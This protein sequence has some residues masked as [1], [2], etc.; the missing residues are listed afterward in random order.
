MKHDCRELFE[1][2][3]LASSSITDYT[4][5]LDRK[6]AILVDSA[7]GAGLTLED[8]FAAMDDLCEVAEMAKKLAARQTKL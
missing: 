2:K 7:I 5:C 4:N 6:A 3:R 8:F 1:Y